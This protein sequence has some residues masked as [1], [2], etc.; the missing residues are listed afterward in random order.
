MT[1][2]RTI[3]PE[4]QRLTDFALPRPQVHVLPNQQKVYAL[5]TGVQPVLQ[6]QVYFHAGKWAEEVP[7]LALFASKMLTE[8]TKSHTA[9]QLNEM[10]E[11]KGIFWG[12]GSENDLFSITFYLLE[13]HLGLALDVLQELLQEATFPEEA[14]ERERKTALQQLAVNESKT[15]YIASRKLRETL[16]GNNHPYG[17]TLSSE[18]LE[19]L[20]LK[21]VVRHYTN[22]IRGR[23][24]T[25]ILVGDVQE[26]HFVLLNHTLGALEATSPLKPQEFPLLPELDGVLQ[27]D[28]WPDALQTSLRIGKPLFDAHHPDRLPFMVMNTLFGGYFGSRLMRNIREE[29]GYTYGISS[30]ISFMLNDTSFRIS[31]E[32]QK[33]HR[34]QALEEVK[35]EMQEL[36]N[37]K[38]SA[39][40]LELV[41]NYMAGGYAKSVGNPDALGSYMKS[42]IFLGLPADYYDRYVSQIYAVSPEQ[43]QQMAQEYLS[44]TF[45]EHLVG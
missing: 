18:L 15:N 6:L 24:F 41:Q 2:N 13:K 33:E 26:K 25:A 40:E 14:M 37:V 30:G 35:K 20:S 23:D 7:G 28:I 43:I 19:G 3:A 34:L 39:S 32:V 44:G 38:V 9:A 11:S 22:C 12:V 4:L 27:D 21:Q 16:Y 42:I 17:Y 36:Q 31:A 1:L 29:K 10:L 45:A 5:Q 8:G